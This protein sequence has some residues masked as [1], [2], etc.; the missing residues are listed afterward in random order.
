VLAGL[1]EADLLQ[2]TEGLTLLEKAFQEMVA[3]RRQ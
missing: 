1:S 2:V 3:A